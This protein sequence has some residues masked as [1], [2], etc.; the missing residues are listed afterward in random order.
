MLHVKGRPRARGFVLDDQR[1][2][3]Q[4][5]ALRAHVGLVRHGA[6]LQVLRE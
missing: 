5:I 1:V 3:A 6:A 4:V 2:V